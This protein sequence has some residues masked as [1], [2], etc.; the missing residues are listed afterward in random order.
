MAEK[1]DVLKIKKAVD[2][3]NPN[4]YLDKDQ[5]RN[6]LREYRD[7]CL[8]AESEGKELPVVSNYLAE[9]FMNISKGL[10]M[11]HNFRN[12]SFIN[13]MIMDGVVVCLKYIRSFDPDKISEKTG[14]P[15]SPLSYF[16]QSCFYAFLN[17]I[18]AEEEEAAIKWSLLLKADL[19]A[20][21]DDSDEGHQLK[22]EDFIKS[23]GPQKLLEKQENKKKKPKK[24][25]E[26]DNPLENL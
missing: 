10:A 8:K 4:Y 12:Y 3:D 26:S 15:V 7:A 13:D 17:R 21:V 11:K 25:V 14:T 16:T 2:K 18:S 23:L 9:C 6:A 24:V 1:N 22:I 19:E 20:Y 5:M